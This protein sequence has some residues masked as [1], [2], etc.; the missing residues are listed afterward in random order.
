MNRTG[1]L[2]RVIIVR[3]L[4]GDLLDQRGDRLGVRIRV[5]GDV[6]PACARV[7]HG[8]FDLAD[9]EIAVSDRIAHEADLAGV[10]SLM[11]DI[12]HI[13]RR[14]ES[15]GD[16]H[17][18][19]PAVEV[20]AVRVGDPRGLRA[21]VQKYCAPADHVAV[22]VGMLL[23][24]VHHITRDPV[25]LRHAV[26]RTHVHRHGVSRALLEIAVIQLELDG[27]RAGCRVDGV[28][29]IVGDRL[30]QRGH[31]L[32]VRPFIQGDVH[33]AGARI[34]RARTDLLLVAAISDDVPIHANFAGT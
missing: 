16:L 17:P 3:V 25:D 23:G 8:V 26:R 11:A 22:G 31:R 20:G 5:K 32:G 21:R 10:E 33:G 13:I 27:P 7:R 29:V 28:D 34:E 9:L 12:Q 19:K 1:I 18:E 4:V 14:M 2:G 30:D 24:V 15:A 6:E